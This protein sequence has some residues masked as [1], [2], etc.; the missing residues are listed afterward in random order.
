[1]TRPRKPRRQREA[2]PSTQ[3]TWLGRALGAGETGRKQAIEHVMSVY[4]QPLRIYLKGSTFRKLGEPD[5]I[6]HGFFASR[7]SRKSYLLDWLASGRQ[8]RFW[9]LTGFRH[10]VYEQLETQR[11]HKRPR[12][13]SPP[14]QP[15]DAEH[16]FHRESGLAIVREAYRRAEAAC[17]AAGQRNHW[18]VFEEHHLKGRSYGTIAVEMGLGERRTA[19]MARTATGKFRRALRELVSWP[20]AGTAE[21]DQE[22]RDLMEAVQR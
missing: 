15:K 14:E 18:R 7:L 21:V 22:L 10:F 16:A 11:R 9:L 12:Q 13:P 20:D 17:V 5:E 8:L 3:V 2:F 1:M 19:V 4:A 6:V